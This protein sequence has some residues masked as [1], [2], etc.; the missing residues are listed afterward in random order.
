METSC[1]GIFPFTMV[2]RFEK[3]ND[4]LQGHSSAMLYLRYSNSAR[5]NSL[6]QVSKGRGASIGNR[7]DEDKEEDGEELRVT[8][9]CPDLP[10]LPVMSFN[11]IGTR[12]RLDHARIRDALLLGTEP[13][14]L[15]GRAKH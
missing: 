11:G 4:T 6:D 5:V 3:P 1:W 12:L 7:V 15:S 10:P 9:R 14:H 13:S 8:E 2:S